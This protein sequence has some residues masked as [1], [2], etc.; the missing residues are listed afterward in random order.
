[1]QKLILD[2]SVRPC[3][4]CGQHSYEHSFADGL[5]VFFCSAYGDFDA[6]YLEVEL[7]CPHDPG[8]PEEAL[9]LCSARLRLPQASDPGVG[10]LLES[11]CLIG[12]ANAGA[13]WLKPDPKPNA[14]LS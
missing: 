11:E 10:T 12:P 1:V 6:E 5:R 9:K 14:S 3:P 7:T 8:E 2:P 4:G 13:K